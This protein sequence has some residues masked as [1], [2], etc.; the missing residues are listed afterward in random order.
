MKTTYILSQP[1]RPDNVRSNDI[2]W[3]L[4]PTNWSS[5][6]RLT[7]VLAWVLR[8]VCNSQRHGGDRQVG[9]ALMPE[10][11][12]EAQRCLI[13]DAQRKEFR[14][15]YTA[16]CDGRRLPRKS[17]LLKLMPKV[18]DDG[19]LRCDG[20]LGYAEF[21]PI[22]VRF[23]I[24]LP[25]RY[26]VTKLIV[27]HY[28]EIGRHI[29]GT[30]HTLGNLSTKYWIV[31][32][33]EEI[34]GWQNEFNECKRR[35]AKAARQVMA[36]LPKTRLRLSLRSFTRILVDFGGPFITVQG[37]GKRVKRWLCLFT[38][39]LSRAVHLKM[40]YGLDTDSFL[41]C[42]TRMAS[43]RGYPQE[44]ISDRGT[45]F[46]GAARELQELVNQLDKKEILERTVDQG[47][48][49]KFNLPL[50]PHFGGAHEIM[51][52]AAKKAIY[53]ILNYADVNDEELLTA[54][55]GAEAL[56]NC[57]PLTYQTSNQKDATPLTPNH[58]LHGQAGGK[59][60][61]ESVDTVAYNPRQRWRRVQEL[62]THFWRRWMK[63]WLPLLN[64]R[65]K[66]TD[67]G[68]DLE[69]GDLALVISPD[70]PRGHRPLCRIIEVFPGKDAHVR[71]AKV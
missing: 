19:I 64:D 8:F 44:I 60:A 29:T 26:W 15:E 24:I 13:R 49:W 58:F 34:R 23:P 20:R 9:L 53:A 3:K 61:P 14:E 37:R 16:I 57:R 28:H 33:R 32:A 45:N 22:D 48:K 1:P 55:I 54:F 52:K 66:C 40:A 25:R 68:R 30:N 63:E 21:L 7:H 67:L 46:I 5:W 41:K 12:E 4:E 62:V 71:V 31:A 38:C 35:R 36:P 65:G 56:L 2:T 59:T 50:A 69:V 6:K 39:L 42:L 11:V 18:D 10:E 47:I 51:I 43:C 17:R 70:Q 27:K